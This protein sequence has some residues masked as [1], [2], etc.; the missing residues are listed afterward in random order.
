MLIITGKIKAGYNLGVSAICY[1]EDG[2]PAKNAEFVHPVPATPEEKP[3]KTLGFF[4]SHD[5]G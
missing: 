5:F 1:L 2:H 3:L 4:T